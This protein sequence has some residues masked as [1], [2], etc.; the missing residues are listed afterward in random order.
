M[1]G[2]QVNQMTYGHPNV[3]ETSG[4]NQSV[5]PISIDVGTGTFDVVDSYRDVKRLGE[6]E[7][8]GH[9]PGW[10]RDQQSMLERGAD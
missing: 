2:Y 1:P 4:C 7:R 5:A 8:H 9:K 10:Q 6:A 3:D